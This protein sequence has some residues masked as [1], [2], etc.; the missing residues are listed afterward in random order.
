MAKRRIFSAAFKEKVALEALA[1]DQTLAE[2]ASRHKVHPN[3]IA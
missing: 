3:P 2:L 1:G